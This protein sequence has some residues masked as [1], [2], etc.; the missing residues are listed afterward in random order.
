M[1]FIDVLKAGVDRGASDIHIVIGKPPMIRLKGEIIPLND[2]SVITADESKRIIY[3]ILY[4]D[5][6][7]KFEETFELDCSFE[8]KGL[9]RFRVNV[10][11]QRNGVEAV[12]RIISSKIPQPESLRLPPAITCL[13]DL[14]RGLV[15]VTGP[16]G[17]G[18]STTLACLIQ[19]INEKY[20]HHILTIED[21]IEFVYEPVNSVIRQREVG[22]Q[23]KSFSN[24][25][26]SALREDPDVI[27]VGEMRDLETISLAL[28]A[29]ETGHLCFGTL[30][31][32][33]AAQTIDRVIDVFPP[34]QQQQVRVQLSS[35]LRAV[36]CQTL[37]PRQD[38]E[39]RI[40]AREI[41]VVTPGISNLIR[42]GKTH[43]INNSIE[44]GSKFGMIT[45][46]KAL[47]ELVKSGMISVEDAC[48]KSNNP[49]LVRAGKAP[50][51]AAVSY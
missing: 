43:M 34:A 23:T 28:T 40:A 45:L 35:V 27:L 16:T 5:Q 12:L 18:K 3:S 17:S 32:T 41:M 24:A 8:I 2:F 4:D 37:L 6:K 44:T 14:P 38:G 33:D 49:D 13:T 50:T 11:K 51:S 15:L 30:H 22:Q 48:A 39:G 36:I 7:Q 46:D 9:S 10:L 31:T 20:S 19:T 1:E 29:A 26:R 25:L 47:I 42:E 21:P